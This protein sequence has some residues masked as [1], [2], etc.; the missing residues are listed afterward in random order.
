MAHTPGPWEC[1]TGDYSGGVYCDNE[2]GSR[3][4]IVYGK[5]QDWPVFSREEEEANA[6][7]IAAAPDFSEAAKR[8]R[9]DLAAIKK[10]AEWCHDSPASLA[11]HI[12]E[13]LPSITASIAALDAAIAKAE[14]RAE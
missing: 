7:L 2:F 10:F 5:G 14:G 13:G 3:V 12:N 1:G 8:A 6:R 9:R 11:G 4:A